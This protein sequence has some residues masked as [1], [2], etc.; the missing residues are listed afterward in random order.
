MIVRRFGL[1]DHPC[2]TLE[3]IGRRLN[4]TSE[5]IRQI[6]AMALRKLRDP[7]KNKFFAGFE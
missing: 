2:E 7:D 3:Q 6:E 5:R 4:L 1:D